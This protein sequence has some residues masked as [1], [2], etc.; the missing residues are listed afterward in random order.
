[1]NHNPFRGRPALHT[2]LALDRTGHPLVSVWATS[3]ED[4]RI[5]IV[6]ILQRRGLLERWQNDGA[7]LERS[8]PL[9]H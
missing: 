6:P 7:R 3:I 8:D 1:M 9:T 2:W 4:A 5:R